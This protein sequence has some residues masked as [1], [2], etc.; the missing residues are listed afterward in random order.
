MNEILA[1]IEDKIADGFISSSEKKEL[2]TSLINIIEGKQDANVL[3]SSLFKL[4]RR[5]MNDNNYLE[6]LTWI[7]TLNKLILQV[8]PDDVQNIQESIYFSPGEDCLDAI[9]RKINKSRHSIYCCVFTISDNR[10]SDALISAHKRGV[11]VKVISDND[12]MYDTGSDIFT[13]KESGIKVK[14]D[15]TDNHMH[16]KFAVFD[17][18]WSLTGSYNWTRSAERY[19]HENLIITNSD[20]IAKR[21]IKEFEYLWEEMQWID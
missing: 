16:H 6:V 5:L 1:L 14:I 19:N 10:I 4:A 11:S 12:K 7:E 3:R 15:D 8:T 2:K 9:I 21:F 13:L 20:K 18:H 17:K